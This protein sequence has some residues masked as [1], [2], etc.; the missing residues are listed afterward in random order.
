MDQT[1][2]D[3]ALTRASLYLLT[4]RKNSAWFSWIGPTVGFSSSAARLPVAEGGPVAVAWIK[5][6]RRETATILRIIRAW[7]GA[8]ARL[9]AMRGKAIL[10]CTDAQHGLAG[11]DGA[12]FNE[13]FS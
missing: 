6:P 13:G 1:G 2:D 4:R 12:T 9:P 3:A 7:K 10:R 11:A 5:D 8:R